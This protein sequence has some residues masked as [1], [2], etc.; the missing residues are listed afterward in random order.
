MA[1]IPVPYHDLF[2]KRTF[3]HL[4]RLM[5]DGTAHPTSGWIDHDA[6]ADRLIVT[7]GR[8]ATSGGTPPSACAV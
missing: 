7:S 1:T 5:P 4:S 6:E 3:A 8:N 2:D